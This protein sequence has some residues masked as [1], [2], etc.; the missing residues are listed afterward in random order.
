MQYFS[1]HR[2]LGKFCE[3]RCSAEWFGNY[4]QYSRATRKIGR[5]FSSIIGVHYVK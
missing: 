4:D 2:A 3:N 1:V 5:P